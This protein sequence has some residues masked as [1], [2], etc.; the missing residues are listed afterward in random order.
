[1][2]NEKRKKTE[3]KKGK[4]RAERNYGEMNELIHHYLIEK[5][6]RRHTAEK[7]G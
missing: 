6:M 7:R 1:M 5:G 4:E 3:G 2:N